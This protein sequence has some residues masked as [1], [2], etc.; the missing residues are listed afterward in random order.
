V[1]R[2]GAWRDRGEKG[3][4]RRGKEGREERGARR[5]EIQESEHVID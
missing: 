1:W 4:E 5:E 3:E 2:E